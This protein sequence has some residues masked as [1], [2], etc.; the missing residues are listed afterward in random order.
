MESSCIYCGCGCRLNYEVKKNKIVKITGVKTD[1]MS[2]G[3]PCVK[4]L[5]IHEVYDKNRIE[6]PTIKGKKVSLGKAL[7]YIYSK[8]KDLSSNEVF[9]NTSGKITNEDNFA[10]QK[11]A[12]VCYKTPNLDSCCGRLC[13]IATVLAMNN[14]FGVANITYVKNAEKTDC[15]FI[16]GSEP[17]KS[18][19]VF[20]N[21]LMRRKNLKI[22]KVHSFL[23]ACD[24]KTCMITIRPGSETCLLNGLINELIKKGVKSKVSGFEI[25]KKRVFTYNANYVCKTCGL[26]KS[27]YIDLVN[28]IYKSKKFSIFH[29]MALTQHMNSLENVHS[30]LNLLLLKKG[31]ILT[32]R[33]EINVQGSGDIGG[34]PG[35]LPTGDMSTKKELEKKWGEISDSKGL[36]ILE[37]LLLSPVKAAFITEFNPFK[38]L[39][40]SN[41]VNEKLKKTFIVY[42][43]AFHTLTSKKADVV[44]PIASLLESEG[45]ITNGERRLRKVNKVIKKNLQLWEIL[46]KF[47]KKFNKSKYFNYKNSKQI[48]S[49]MKL[50]VKAYSKINTAKLWKGKDEWAD[51]KIKHKRFMPEPFDGLDDSTSKKYPF[52]L[53]TYRSKYSFL[54]NEITKN[55]KTLSKHREAAGF[56]FNI[57]D[58]KKLKLKNNTKIIV[59]SQVG[60]IKAKAFVS[61]MIPK[62]IVGAYM[63]YLKINTLFPTNFDEESFTPNYKGVAVNVKLLD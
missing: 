30:L 37:A 13:H 44:I 62:G 43:G 7:D 26:S 41:E 10:I 46:Q 29:G 23:K 20:Y 17:S 34:S 51:K 18:Y 11:F 15:I 49:E 57:D 45:T 16:I 19:P 28:D 52:L 9:F 21:K 50:L 48:F 1:D 39:P 25:L 27:K 58:A 47:S 12:R 35:I 59:S 56:Y 4:G 3:A 14:V 22:I 55:S 24:S 6:Y 36:N 63:H 2:D 33:G 60:T 61:D 5:T 54:C 8:T 31:T 38:S 42:F 53:T 40:N 32:L